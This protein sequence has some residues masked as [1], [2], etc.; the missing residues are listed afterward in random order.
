MNR[1]NVPYIVA[2][3]LLV[4]AIGGWGIFLTGGNHETPNTEANVDAGADADFDDGGV[5]ATPET[6]GDAGSGP[7]DSG[8]I[9]LAAPPR[10]T[11]TGTSET[12]AQP[13]AVAAAPTRLGDGEAGEGA[14]ETAG[15][16]TGEGA[17]EGAG[18]T[19]G[20]T[21]GETAGEKPE[22]AISPDAIKGVVAS[23]KPAMKA[24]Y[25]S[26]LSDFPDASGKVLVTFRI[27]AEADEGRV[28]VIE[29]NEESTLMDDRLLGCMT[30][31]F[32]DAVFPVPDGGD[33]VQVTFPFTFATK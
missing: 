30:D 29:V 31:A 13:D 22:G 7:A 28:T 18:E 16:T 33:T 27:E 4:L 20:E 32:G 26:V 3:A 1:S 24:C 6:E 5:V 15:E 12:H 25:N 21:A 10:M 11:D 8:G 17:G 2:A 19:T 14:G 23:M 9:K